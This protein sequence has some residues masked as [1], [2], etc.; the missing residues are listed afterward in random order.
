[1]KLEDQVVSL[2]LAKRLKELKCSQASIFYW[3]RSETADPNIDAFGLP[4]VTQIWQER[5]KFKEIYSAYN[6]AELF[7][8]LPASL[9]IKENEPF[10]NFYLH[11]DKRHAKN[12]QYIANYVGD[13]ARYEDDARPL[14]VNTLF[15][16]GSYSE[17]LAEALGELLVRIIEKGICHD[18]LQR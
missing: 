9:D 13:S 18:K 14:M 11:V 16:P 5:D 10:N 1:M 8:M 4:Y 12:I 17:N 3:I 7:D 15:R 6:P 2:N